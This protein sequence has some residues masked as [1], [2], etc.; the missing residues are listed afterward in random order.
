M[1]GRGPIQIGCFAKLVAGK[2]SQLVGIC[3]KFKCLR[4]SKL[5]ISKYA[6]WDWGLESVT[7]E[8]IQGLST[9]APALRNGRGEKYLLEGGAWLILLK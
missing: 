8:N 2:A 9:R 1:E 7:D 4:E 5:K 6:D 3:V